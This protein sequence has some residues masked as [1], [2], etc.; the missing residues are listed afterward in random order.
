MGYVTGWT[1]TLK[2]GRSIDYRCSID[3]VT[4]SGSVHEEPGMNTAVGTRYVVAFDSLDPRNHWPYYDSPVPDSAA[5]P[6]ASGWSP[7][8]FARAQARWQQGPQDQQ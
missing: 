6:P 3:G 1:Q 8:F 4:Y 7:H 5:L 2:N